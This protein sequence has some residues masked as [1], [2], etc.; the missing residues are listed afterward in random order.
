MKHWLYLHFP[1]LQLDTLFAESAQPTALVHGHQHKIVQLNA[2]ARAQGIQ[3]GMGLASAATLCHE[4]NVVAYDP[5]ME[6][7]AL[8]GIAQWL[9][10]V[11]SDIVL[12]PPQGLLLSITPMLTLYSGL[13]NYWQAISQHLQK[14]AVN[15]HYSTGFSPL[16][17]Q[18]LAQHQQHC[19]TLDNAQLKRALLPIDLTMTD[20]PAQHIESLRRVGTQTIEALIA[21]PLAD[22]ARRFDIDVVNYVGRL[23]EQFHHPLSEYRPSEQFAAHLPLLYE[24]SHTQWLETPL[25]RL[26]IQLEAFLRLRNQVAYELTLTLVQRDRQTAQVTFT[27]AQGEYRHEAWIILCRLHL[28]SITLE[29]PVIE[30]TLSVAR[31]GEMDSQSDDLFQGRTGQQSESEL[32]SLLQAKLGHEHVHQPYFTDDPRPE[33][34]THYDRPHTSV[35]QAERRAQLRPTLLY[36]P[37]R[38]LTDKVTIVQG[39]ERIAT[40]WWDNNILIRDYFIARSR[41]GR[42]LWIYRTPEKKWW[43]HGVFS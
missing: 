5:K 20:L 32:L 6:I 43:V 19:L 1:Q 14:H 10:L 13:E 3:E 12:F 25:Q 8:E 41:E 17:A 11:T 31:S 40:G 7:K 28:E 29:H 24:L 18:L 37:P 9:Y 30:M 22:L 33:S 42:W 36:T 21:I 26:L 38:A 34:S 4:L 35:K 16:C 2:L 15:Y 39:P 27:A 23:L